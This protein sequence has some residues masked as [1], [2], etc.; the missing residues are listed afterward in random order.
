MPIRPC[1]N[2]YKRAAQGRRAGVMASDGDWVN[3]SKSASATY[4]TYGL[5]QI[6]SAFQVKPDIG[7][8]FAEVRV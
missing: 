3:K 7:P 1:W 5:G 6:W 4:E 2:N 8:P